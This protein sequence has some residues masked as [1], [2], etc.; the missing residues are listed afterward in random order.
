M[1]KRNV[2]I[3]IIVFM[4]LTNI[5]LV[6]RVHSNIMSVAAYDAGISQRTGVGK[7]ESF[8]TKYIGA[9]KN[10]NATYE[11]RERAE[12]DTTRAITI[13][14]VMDVVCV[15]ALYV[16]N[17]K[18]KPVPVATDDDEWPGDRRSRRRRLR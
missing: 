18:P 10:F 5:Y 9:T 17:R 14:F 16:L 3:A 8:W 15:G 4:I 11:D 13:L 1:T 7:L 6:L 2:S 12:S